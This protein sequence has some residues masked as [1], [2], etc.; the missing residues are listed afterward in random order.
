[1]TVAAR[2]IAKVTQLAPGLIRAL[3]RFGPVPPAARLLERLTG[4]FASQ[5]I[6]A[7]AELGLAD[8]IGDGTRDVASLADELEV[9]AGALLRLLRA[10]SGLNLVREDTR[11]FRLTA[12]GQLLRSGRKDSLR[13]IAISAGGPWY[14]SF[15]EL[16]NSVRAGEPSFEGIYGEPF[17]SY[18]RSNPE[19]GELFDAAMRGV[20]ATADPVIAVAYDFSRHERVVDVGGGVGG[21]LCAILGQHHGVKGT[22]FELPETI[23]RARN[24]IDPKFAPRIGLHAGNFFEAVVPGGDAY[25]LKTVLHDWD[26][27]SARRILEAC[28]RAVVPGGRLLLAEHVIGKGNAFE[29]GKMLDLLMLS[30]LGGRERTQAEYASL[31]DAAGFRLLRVLPTVSPISIVEAVPV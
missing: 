10:L 12:Q 13:A 11:G 1:M 14:R 24:H 18:T 9:D 5:A 26:D 17:F 21:Q 2:T 16:A 23:E 29:F 19:F 28:R 27:A 7:A 22:L 8:A 6:S 15:G 31:L 4:Y 30:S 20:S 3:G 25:L